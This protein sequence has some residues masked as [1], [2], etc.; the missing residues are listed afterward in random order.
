MEAG[1]DGF[2][3]GYAGSLVESDQSRSINNTSLDGSV[4]GDGGGGEG[5]HIMY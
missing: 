1:N 5:R 3:C 2:D 4:N